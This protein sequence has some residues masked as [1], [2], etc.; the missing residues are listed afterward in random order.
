MRGGFGGRSCRRGL[1][2]WRAWQEIRL[3]GHGKRWVSPSFRTSQV[4]GNPTPSPDCVSRRGRRPTIPRRQSRESDKSSPPHPTSA[5]ARQRAALSQLATIAWLL[6]QQ[7]RRTAHVSAA[8]PPLALVRLG[9]LSA[10]LGQRGVCAWRA[11]TFAVPSS[12]SSSP[13]R[14]PPPAKTTTGPAKFPPRRLIDGSTKAA[15]RGNA[16]VGAPSAARLLQRRRS[17]KGGKRRR[18]RLLLASAVG[19]SDPH[20]P[21]R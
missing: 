19:T 4:E 15:R 14:P 9:C 1:S 7:T 8:P 18:R 21:P 11:F 2:E 12:S 13:D 10:T 5:R 16:E 17:C 6:L 3:L 20:P